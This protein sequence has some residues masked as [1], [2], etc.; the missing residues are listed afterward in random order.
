MTG[1]ASVGSLDAD[2]D[3]PFSKVL[4]HL[5]AAGMIGYRGTNGHWG[6]MVN[7]LFMGLSTTKD[8][9]LGGSARADLNQSMLEVDGAWR[10]AKRLELYFGLRGNDIDADV[11][12]RPA[13]G[14][15]QAA[16]D[17]KTW[18]DPLVG[19]RWE[20]PIGAKWTFV[21]RADVGGFG[22]GSDFAWNAM[23]HFDW[24]I[25]KRWGAAFGYIALDMDYK[26]GEGSDFFRY[27]ILTT[28]PMAAATLRW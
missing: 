15:N 1:Q 21:G 28:G 5:Q 18:V 23:A 26:D 27:D 6:V 10:F 2:V 14:S 9:R 11:E 7:A 22:V 16:S 3:V 8:G 12:L 19:L 24:A 13:I 4:E 17:R 20:A 25:S